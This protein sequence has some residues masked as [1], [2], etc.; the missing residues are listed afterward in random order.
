MKKIF[1][2]VFN[3]NVA[4][5]C[6]S[7][8]DGTLDDEYTEYCVIEQ[9]GKK[10]HFLKHEGN[11]YDFVRLYDK[12]SVEAQFSQVE[13]ISVR[14]YSLLTMYT[15][16]TAILTTAYYTVYENSSAKFAC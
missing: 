1:A 3:E 13:D 11:T 16:L 10:F 2:I 15:M 4:E 7:P 8:L 6:S 5:S 12:L 9:S 14:F